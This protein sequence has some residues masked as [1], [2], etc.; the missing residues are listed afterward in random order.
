MGKKVAL[1]TGGISSERDVA[2]RSATNVRAALEKNYEVT[3]FDFP[4]Q[5]DSFL[6]VYRTFNAAVPVF[7]GV[8]GEDGTVQGLLET[9]R[10]PY[11]FSRASAHALGI[12]KARTKQIAT[13]IGIPTPSFELVCPGGS[14]IN[15]WPA[16]VKPNLGGSSIGVTMACNAEALA[17]IMT[18]RS[19]TIGDLLIEDLVGGS[20]VT[21]AV[22][23][24]GE[25][26]A[27]PPILILPKD[28]FFSNKTKYD[29]TMVEEICPAPLGANVIEDLT[30][31]SL[32]IHAA[33]G[34]RHISRS[35]FIVDDA[36]KIWFLE[37]NTIPGI[38]E[39][40][41]LPKAITV[42]G[43]NFSKLLQQWIESVSK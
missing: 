24:D 2:L 37:I 13:S 9:L 23:D 22:I 8:G 20:E 26:V 29:P 15:R 14:W 35:D 34:C 41:L 38:T 1:L 36:G 28:D 19:E 33:I 31:T 3:Q 32:A 12:N 10:V 27:L 21:V 42:S 39:H 43:R 7:H 30:R 11:I 17:S 4:S 18:K 6:A 5:L 16:V 40:S 25:T